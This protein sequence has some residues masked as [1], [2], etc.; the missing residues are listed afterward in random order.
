MQ[1]NKKCK[2]VLF[3]DIHYLDKRPEK[4]DFAL[5]RKLTQYAIPI[6]EKLTDKINNNLKPDISINLGDLIEDTYNH[7][8]DIANLNYI[9]QQ[10][11]A[12]KKPFYSTV[13]NHDLRIM[14]QREEVENIMGY[15]HSTFSVDINGYHFILLGMELRHD[16]GLEEGGIFK[17][18]YISKED[19]EWLKKT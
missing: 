7:D 15:N 4:I 11:Q 13:G 16:L 10:L 9:W 2:I 5:N 12:I 18:Q 6:L 14:N 8:R 1:K 3:T 19:I 17:A